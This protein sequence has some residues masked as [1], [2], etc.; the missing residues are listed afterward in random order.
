MWHI[1]KVQI[2]DEQ[3]FQNKNEL[4]DKIETIAATVN[5]EKNLK[6]KSLYSSITLS[7]TKFVPA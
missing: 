2:Y 4:W 7:N 5:K 1:I 6:I 3:M